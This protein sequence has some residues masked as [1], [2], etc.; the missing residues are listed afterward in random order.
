MRIEI[1]SQSQGSKSKLVSFYI[2]LAFS[3]LRLWEFF[4]FVSWFLTNIC[5]LTIFVLKG[6]NDGVPI[7][8]NVCESNEGKPSSGY[9]CQESDDKCLFG[10]H[11][12]TYEVEIHGK[13]K[14]VELFGW[15]KH[16]VQKAK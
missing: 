11:E 12:R 14:I 8:W 10:W 13:W 15:Y 6:T 7:V 9:Y 4:I 2:Y 5:E 16:G 1:S 3:P